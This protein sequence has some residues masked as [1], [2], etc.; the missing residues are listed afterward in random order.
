[1]YSPYQ[2]VAE[3]VLTAALSPPLVYCMEKLDPENPLLE[4]K[5]DA[6]TAITCK[7]KTAKMFRG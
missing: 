5:G 7:C 1:M 3:Q 2:V 6:K 4:S